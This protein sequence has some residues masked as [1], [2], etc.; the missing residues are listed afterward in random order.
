MEMTISIFSVIFTAPMPNSRRALMIPIPRSSIKWRILSGELPTN[1]LL[2]TRRISTA[3]SAIRRWPRLINSM[4]VS[5]LPTPLSPKISTPS[6]YTSTSTPWRVMRG[7]S[8]TFRVLMRLER[9]A[10]VPSLVRTRG[11]EYFSAVSLMQSNI[12]SPLVTTMTGGL[13]LKKVSRQLFSSSAD[14]RPI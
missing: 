13:W 11:T 5:L 3:S 9:K 12:S 6:P 2:E 7:A 10:E 14:S 8:S 4:A 1:V